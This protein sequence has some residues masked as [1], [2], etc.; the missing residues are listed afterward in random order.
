ML[1]SFFWRI[2]IKRLEISNFPSNFLWKTEIVSTASSAL[3]FSH[4]VSSADLRVFC[5]L[6]KRK[7]VKIS[8]LL[9]ESAIE[10]TKSGC[11][12]NFPHNWKKKLER[13]FR[14]GEIW[15]NLVMSAKLFY[16]TFMF[17]IAAFISLACLHT[18]QRT[19]KENDNS[20]KIALYQLANKSSRSRRLCCAL[21]L[22]FFVD[23]FTE[24]LEVFQRPR[25]S[26]LHFDLRFWRFWRL[27]TW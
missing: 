25:D 18:K 6:E 22:C 16:F 14:L 17:Q 15:K 26:F 1:G 10:G 12:I 21:C 2:S 4:Q 27:K 5:S 7:R 20:L 9:I 11:G 23:F 24:C 19:R 8:C 13:T 3:L